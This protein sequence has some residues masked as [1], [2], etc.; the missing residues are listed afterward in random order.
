MLNGVTQ[1]IM[2]KAD[3]LS[4]FSEINVCTHYEY[5]NEKI[6]YM[7]YDIIDEKVTPI[8]KSFPGWSEDLTG[9]NSVTELPNSLM[10][11]ILYLEKEL[12]VPISIISVGPDRTQT[13][14]R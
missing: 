5:R 14:M 12:E 11:Y 10:D 13:L 2:T 6:D 3:V 4:G 7:P 9:L 8:Y 1:L